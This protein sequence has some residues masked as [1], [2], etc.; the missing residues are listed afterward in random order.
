MLL[1]RWNGSTAR[2]MTDPKLLEVLR[3]LKLL[4][5][6]SF[7]YPLNLVWS[8]CNP[9]GFLW[10]MIFS[11]TPM[12]SSPFLTFGML[13]VLDHGITPAVL[14]EIHQEADDC[15][16]TDSSLM[17]LGIFTSEWYSTWMCWDSS[18]QRLGNILFM[19]ISIRPSLL[20]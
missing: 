8:T 9:S 14:E 7:H 12:S 10:M 15:L 1:E 4:M 17:N 13:S 6:M 20:R 19:C 18:L 2:F 11:N 16:H 3:E 5:D